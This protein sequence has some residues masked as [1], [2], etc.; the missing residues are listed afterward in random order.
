MS[1]SDGTCSGLAVR[2]ASSAVAGAPCWEVVRIRLLGEFDVEGLAERD[3]GSRKSR[4]LVKVL[5]SAHGRPVSSDQLVDI[6]W[7]DALPIRPA[8]QLQVLISRLRSTFGADRFV[9]TRRR[10]RAAL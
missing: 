1:I 4:T 7:P 8:E 5:A 10:L 2:A 9:R 6:L 3:I